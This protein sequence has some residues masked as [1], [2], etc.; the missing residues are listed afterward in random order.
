MT[1]VREFRG[2]EFAVGPSVLVPRPD[3]ETLVEAALERAPPGPGRVLDLGTGSG[4]LL[5]ALLVEWPAAFGVGVDSSPDALALASV[6]ARALGMRGC[7]AFV[8]SDWSSALAGA[9]N[10]VVCNA[11]R[12]RSPERS[13]WWFATRFVVERSL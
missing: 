5:L 2:L 11:I 1:G 6:N 10:V 7:L 3:S 8:A 4:C 12:P 13:M 9:F